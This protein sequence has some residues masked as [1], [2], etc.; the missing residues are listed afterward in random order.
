MCIL[1]CI[2]VVLWFVPKSILKYVWIYIY[3]YIYILICVL[4]CILRCVL[5][6]VW[7]IFIK[8][9]INICV[10][11]CI[12][13]SKKFRIFLYVILCIFLCVFFCFWTLETQNKNSKHLAYREHEKINKIIPH[14]NHKCH[15]ELRAKQA[16]Q[17]LCIYIYIYIQRCR[18]RRMLIHAICH[19]H[20]R[21]WFQNSHAPWNSTLLHL[22]LSGGVT[23]YTPHRRSWAS[24][25]IDN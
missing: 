18:H 14:L 6:Y 19:Y 13:V 20:M 11:M 24:K 17:Q 16:P 10:K 22:C 21:S 1:H 4:K 25:R 12:M 9:C 8:I 3:I 15:S 5:N 2:N 23:L 7:K